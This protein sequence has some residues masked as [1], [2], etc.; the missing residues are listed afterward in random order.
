MRLLG[1]MFNYLSAEAT[2]HLTFVTNM[3]SHKEM[4]SAMYSL[5]QWRLGFDPGKLQIVIDIV[6]LLQKFLTYFPF[7]CYSLFC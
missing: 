6:A 7:P 2:L 4:Q 3:Y 5:S 1:V